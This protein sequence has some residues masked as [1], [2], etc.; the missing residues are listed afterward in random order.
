MMSSHNVPQNFQDNFPQILIELCELTLSRVASTYCSQTVVKNGETNLDL[1][2]LCI[3]RSS[4][5]GLGF[6]ETESLILDSM[7]TIHDNIL[8]G[9]TIKLGT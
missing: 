2:V 6:W 1:E 8:R 7:S 4:F 9:K 3:L 5:S